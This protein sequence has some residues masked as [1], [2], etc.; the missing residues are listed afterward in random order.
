MSKHLLLFLHLIRLLALLC[1]PN[2]TK[3][4]IAENLLLRKQLITVSRKYK[5]S[6]NLSF[7]N[8]FIFALLSSLIRP[9]RLIKSAIIIK[10]ATFIKFHQAFVKQK[11]IREIC[12]HGILGNTYDYSLKQCF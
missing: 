4:L 9:A 2:G 11:V 5:R 1:K 8:R 12:N 6:P 3:A 7:W 10:P